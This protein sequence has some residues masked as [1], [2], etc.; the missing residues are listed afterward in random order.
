MFAGLLTLFVQVFVVLSIVLPVWVALH[1]LC[2]NG[3]SVFAVC[4]CLSCI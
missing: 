1:L 4:K 3:Q 2:Q